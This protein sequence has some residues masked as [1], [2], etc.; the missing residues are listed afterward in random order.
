M[1]L[2]MQNLKAYSFEPIASGSSGNK[3]RIVERTKTVFSTLSLDAFLAAKSGVCTHICPFRHAHLWDP[4]FF[5]KIH[6][7]QKKL[8]VKFRPFCVGRVFFSMHVISIYFMSSVDRLAKFN[9]EYC[10]HTGRSPHV[11][12]AHFNP[13]AIPGLKFVPMSLFRMQRVHLKVIATWDTW[14]PR[15]TCQCESSQHCWDDKRKQY[16]RHN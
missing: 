14:G 16:F 4:T 9:G 5:L 11:P 8:E 13:I 7:Q 1:I 12:L 10:F 6:Y 3:L 2:R 15:G